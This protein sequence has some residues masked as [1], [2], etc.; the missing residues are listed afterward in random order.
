MDHNR[1]L[2]L[3][4]LCLTAALLGGCAS[5]P[6]A[7]PQDPLEP[8]NRS[9]TRF[10][11]TVD[12][13]VLKPVATGYRD[14][15]PHPVR[16]GVGNFFGNLRDAWSVVNGVLQGRPKEAAQ[17]FMR[18]NVNTV[19][20]LGGLIDIASDMG[21]ERTTMDFGQTMGRWGMPSG[22]YV[23][24]PL[25][26]PSTVRDTVGL[27]V[28]SQADPVSQGGA[29]VA[30]RNSG[31]VLRAVDTRASLLGTTDLLEQAALD[32]YTFVRDAYLQ[33]RDEQVNGPR[34]EERYDE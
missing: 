2:G 24:L 1:R 9:V 13:A 20:G 23:V 8:M 21:I 3:W 17:D 18:V 22:A 11:D 28:D 27:V 30:L 19:F 4:S 7:H 15:L 12:E 32:K 14:T 6:N 33:R 5:G 29:D 34:K 26:G 10:N 16:T 25:F 31:Q